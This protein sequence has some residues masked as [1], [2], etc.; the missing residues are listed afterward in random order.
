M[1]SIADESTT[2]ADGSAS[3]MSLQKIH[4]RLR[5]TAGSALAPLHAGGDGKQGT[6]SPGQGECHTDRIDVCLNLLHA[7]IMGDF[8][9]TGHPRTPVLSDTVLALRQLQHNNTLAASTSSLDQVCVRL[10]FADGPQSVRK[11]SLEDDPEPLPSVLQRR[12][13]EVGGSIN[14]KAPDGEVVT[15]MGTSATTEARPE[16][17]EVSSGPG[18]QP[19]ASSAPPPQELQPSGSKALASGSTARYKQTPSRSGSSPLRRRLERLTAAAQSAARAVTSVIARERPQEKDFSFSQ[20]R[21]SVTESLATPSSRAAL[22]DLNFANQAN[23]GDL[24]PEQGHFTPFAPI[25]KSQ[26]PATA[27]TQRLATENQGLRA[28]IASAVADKSRCVRDNHSIAKFASMQATEVCSA[29]LVS[30]IPLL[31]A[32]GLNQNK[33]RQF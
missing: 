24:D 9:C 20:R 7:P 8:P 13:E 31:C 32:L 17:G 2:Q 33:K 16:R 12:S 29:N 11:A 27:R 18:R 4:S 22:A 25:G 3:R 28:S 19:D 15:L 14:N 5:Q 1:P 10:D 21:T 23:R 26:T 30:H 6:T